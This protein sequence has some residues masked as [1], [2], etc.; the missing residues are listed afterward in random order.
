MANAN[1]GSNAWYRRKLEVGKV[2]SENL[3]IF[4]TISVGKDLIEVLYAKT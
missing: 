2:F 3:K 1:Y 4:A